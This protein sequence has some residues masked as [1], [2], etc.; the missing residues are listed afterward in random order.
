MFQNKL[1]VAREYRDRKRREKELA[2]ENGWAEEAAAPMPSGEEVEE[3]N[4]GAMDTVEQVTEG[5]EKEWRS[6][7]G[8]AEWDELQRKTLLELGLAVEWN[9]DSCKVAGH[10]EERGGGE[11]EGQE[12]VPIIMGLKLLPVTPTVDKDAANED[13]MSDTLFQLHR[14]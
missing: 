8:E 10:E 1:K 5:R 12:D 3:G 6:G 2:V 9:K 7:E 13:S 11:G 4:L 14:D